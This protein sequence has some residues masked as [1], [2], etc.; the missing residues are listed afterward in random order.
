MNLAWAQGVLDEAGETGFKPRLDFEPGRCCVV[1][2][3]E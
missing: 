3:N 2:R 1:F